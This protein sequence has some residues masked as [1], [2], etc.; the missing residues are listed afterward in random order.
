MSSTFGI[1]EAAK[2]GLS[3][4]MQNL[5]ITS[6]NIANANTEGYT[7]QRLITSAKETGAS[8]Y[9]IRPLSIENIGQGVE[10]LSA[11][12]VR[13]DYLDTQYRKLNTGYSYYEYRTQALDYMEGM[14]NAELEDGEGLT[15]AIENFYGA[16]KDFVSDTTSQDKR[17]VVQQTAE[18][19]TESFNLIYSEMESLWEDQNNS[20][21]LTADNINNIA[22]KIADLNQAITAYERGGYAANDLRDE[23]NLL[24]DKLSG[25]VNIT[26]STNAGNS[27]M[28]DVKVGGVDLVVG[29]IANKIEASCDADIID[30]IT[31]QIANINAAIESAGSATTAQLD[32]LASLADQLDD[33]IMIGISTNASG[34][35]D[36]AYNGLSL[37]AGSNA[38]SIRDAEKA[39][40]GQWAQICAK[41]LTLNGDELSIKAGTITGGELYAHMEMVLSTSEATPGVPYYMNQLNS[42][43]RD[44]AKSI[45][46]IHLTGYSYDTDKSA[47]STTSKNGIYFFNV[48]TEKDASGNVTAEYYDRLT[49]GTFSV[50]SDILSSVWNIAGSSERV[51]S[52]GV[53]MSSGNS[54][55]AQALFDTLN[56][57]AFYDDLNTV[58]DHL[59]VTLDNSRSLLDTRETLLNNADT[60]RT[61]ISG[62][63]TDEEATNLIV[64]QQTYKACSRV[65][66]AI[67]DMLEALLNI[68]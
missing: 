48:E 21:G 33:Y 40:P 3:V 54:V 41:K 36:I 39:E 11:Q 49:A 7:R 14:F 34:G 12:Q 16:L 67:D 51:Y 56:T 24:L 52:D 29:N 42:L 5:N 4:A 66:S 44:I 53:T 10:V 17:V 55:V 25:Y 31:A 2:S 23:R 57:N 38:S 8:T 30:N 65:I 68:F 35:M 64:Y 6:H 18:G 1:F 45:N 32:E 26:Y 9:L 61:A 59:A 50:S 63:S 19:L 58:V 46:D 43:A 15:G 22:K 47:A 20:I 60:Q 27:S 28:V 13:V 37:V 62:V